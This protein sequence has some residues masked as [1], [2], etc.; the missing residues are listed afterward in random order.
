[1]QT[2]KKSCLSHLQR[3]Y[4]LQ[5]GKASTSNYFYMHLF[6]HATQST[7]QS[8]IQAAQA[9]ATSYTGKHKQHK[10][11]Q[12]I[13]QL[14]RQPLHRQPV[15]QATSY[16][17][18]VSTSNQL[19]RQRRH[20]QPVTLASTS[21]AGTGKQLYSC[22]G[23]QLHRQPVTQATQAR[24][25]VHRQPGIQLHRQAQAQAQTAQA[26]QAQV[27][28]FTNSPRYTDNAISDKR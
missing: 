21:N 15:T 5:T 17:R 20:R 12:A 2:H 7:R 10:H 13:I 3:V 26:T 1:M 24:Q 9:Q 18:S 11:R 25:A 6:L 22:T 8:V 23:N 4:V 14:H 16:T 27:T 28:S 19:Y